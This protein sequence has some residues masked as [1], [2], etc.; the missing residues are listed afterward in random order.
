MTQVT[1]FLPIVIR[2]S[3]PLE[4]TSRLFTVLPSTRSI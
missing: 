3:D 4:L 2:R 1:H